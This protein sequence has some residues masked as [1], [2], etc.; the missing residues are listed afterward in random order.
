M[1]T[2]HVEMK[3]NIWHVTFLNWSTEYCVIIIKFPLNAWDMSLMPKTQTTFFWWLHA[4]FLYSFFFFLLYWKC[5]KV[6][7][8][9]ARE[10]T[11]YELFRLF[12]STPQGTT[13]VMKHRRYFNIAQLCII[14]KQKY[15]YPIL[16]LSCPSIVSQPHLSIH[17]S[18][19]NQFP[20]FLHDFPLNFTLSLSLQGIA[21]IIMVHS[22]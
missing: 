20:S 22:T 11:I 2:I 4:F 6:Y 13:H 1:P 9:W 3:A 19:A 17:A 18:F 21:V 7:N 5:G 8:L 10:P 14:F 15:S 16:V 12:S